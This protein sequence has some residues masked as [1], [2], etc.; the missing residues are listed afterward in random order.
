[1]SAVKKV[2]KPSKKKKMQPGGLKKPP[3]PYLEFSKEM[4][5]RVLEEKGSMSFADLSKE[6]GRRWKEL[7]VGSKSVYEERSK[8]NWLRYREELRLFKLTLSSGNC[9][10]DGYVA[11]ASGE[12]VHCSGD[13]E[14]DG[15]QIEVV[16][17]HHDIGSDPD[18][19]SMCCDNGGCGPV[20]G[21]R[22][23]DESVSGDY[24][25]GCRDEDVSVSL[26]SGSNTTVQV[27]S[28]G[29]AKEKG[30][31][32]YPAVMSSSSLKGKRI[33][34]TF[35]GSGDKRIVSNSNWRPYSDQSLSKILNS[36][37]AQSSSFQLG[38]KQLYM[39]QVKVSNG[40]VVSLAAL[41]SKSQL[42]KRKFIRLS[43][44][45]LQIE[46]EENNRKM[47]LIMYHDE[48]KNLWRC[49]NCPWKDRFKI[50]AKAHARICGARRKV[51]KKKCNDQYYCSRIDCEVSFSSKEDLRRH[52]R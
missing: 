38:M 35:L 7:D 33:S 49:K 11:S 9:N 23:C 42:P 22:E 39:L 43:K 2:H 18:E 4:R 41:P 15:D 44:D 3:S 40:E 21:G 24:G 30:Y 31:P 25:V 26:I 10:D 29:F 36:K 47:D 46:E 16:G 32:W 34:V 20:E 12:V 5:V 1:M 17:S 45:H 19:V 28:L 48:P 27:D 13:N 37:I 14:G 6:L 52:Y 8:M 51:S 50:R